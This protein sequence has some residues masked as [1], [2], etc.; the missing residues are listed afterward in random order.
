[1]NIHIVCPFCG[2]GWD[3]IMLANNDRSR[4][5]DITE[6]HGATI[7]AEAE[8]KAGAVKLVQ[9]DDVFLLL[10]IDKRNK[11]ERKPVC[12]VVEK[13]TATPMYTQAVTDYLGAPP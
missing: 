9:V 2:R 13:E 8:G 10:I 5:V 11:V 4:E 12:K 7:V 6:L 1:M 3:D